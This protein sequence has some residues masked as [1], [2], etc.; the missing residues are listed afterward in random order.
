MFKNRKNYDSKF[1]AKLALEAIIGDR[2][3]SQLSSDYGVHPNQIGLWK[4]K[5]LNGLP[6]IFDIKENTGAKDNE[7]E[8]ELYRQIG[9]LK[10]ELDWIKKNPRFYNRRETLA[11][12]FRRRYAFIQTV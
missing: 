2:T 10:V 6:M 4:K 12:K 1:K 5:L 8:S 7:F 11:N 9:E 3:I